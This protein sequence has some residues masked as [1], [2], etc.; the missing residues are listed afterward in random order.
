MYIMAWD[1]MGVGQVACLLSLSASRPPEGS[2][3]SDP[4]GPRVF[5]WTVTVGFIPQGG[6]YM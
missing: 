5:R 4:P 1:I 2:T 6:T 3:R